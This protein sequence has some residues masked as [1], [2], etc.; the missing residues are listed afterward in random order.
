MKDHDKIKGQL[1]SELAEL[2][3]RIAELEA[4]ESESKQIEQALQESERQFRDLYENAPNA[5]LSVGVD[6]IVRRCNRR[7]AELLGYAMEDLVGRPVFELYADTPHGRGK[8]SQLFECFRAGEA[9]AG[10]EL[11]MQKADGTPLWI[12][13]TVNAVHDAHGQIVESRSMVVDITERKRAE[14]A[15]RESEERF[16]QMA[17]NTRDIFW[18]RDLK[19]RELIYVSPAYERLW[20]HS[21]QDA[22]SEPSS[23]MRNVHPEDRERVT[24]AFEKQ[25]RGEPT[26][27]EYRILW[28]DGSIRWIRDRAFPIQDQAG[29]PYRMVGV[30]EDFTDRKQVEK[31]LERR[32]TQ[33]ATLNR[34]GRYVESILDRQRLLQSAV[35]AVREELGYLQAA[36]LL[37]GVDDA[38]KEASELYVA[39]ATDNFW[40]IIPDNYRQPVGEGAIG[41]AAQTGETV[42]VRDASSDPRVY[43]IGE[44]L[45]PSSVSA[46]I[47]VG[48][49]VIE[50]LEVESDVPDAFD[51]NDLIVINTLA[52]QVAVAIENARLYQ[53]AKQE[54]S[55]RKQAEEERER[56]LVQIQ[57]QA[58]RVRQIIDT[59]PEGMLLLDADEQIVLANPVAEG[60]LSLLADVRVGGIVTRLG[61]RPL[62]ELLTSPPKGM[63]HEV[64]MDT[65][66]FQVIARPIEAGPTPGGWVMVIRDVTQQREIEQRVRQQERLA[67][68]GQL[69]AGIAHDFNNIMATI[70]L[71]A[72]MTAR[73]EGLPA[74]VRERMETIDQQ[75]Q[76]ATNLIQQIL[77]FSRRA[78]LER[79]PLDLALLLR[80]HVGLLKRTLPE[81]IE[82]ELDYGPGPSKAEEPDECA[83]PL[84]VNADPT[85]MQQMVTNLALNARDAMPEGGDLYIG[86][87]RIGVRPG[88]SPLLPEM[89]PG[90]WI[91]V[92]VSDT[93]TGIPPNVLPHIFEP[94][95]TTRAPLGSGLGLA[96][97]YGIV[98][99]HGGRID[100]DTEVGKGTTFTIYLP[101]HL[102]EQSATARSGGLSALATGQGEIILIVEDDTAVR[103]ALLDSL[104]GLNYTVL[105]A[106][107]GQEALTLL[108][109]YGDDIALLLSDVVMP[110]MGGMALLHALK[111]KGL[112]VPVVMLTGHLL[113]KELEDLRAQD[114]I[115]WLPKPPKLEQLAEVVA[116]ALGAD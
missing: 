71:Y 8:A 20:G 11:Q 99:Q 21:I 70:V 38:E 65:R 55:E 40:E 24:V 64:A 14:E 79:R 48:G 102:A 52:D 5:Y 3:R 59:V 66:S 44:W 78:V 101:V 73:M 75:A 111:E 41:M 95:F 114:I 92:T 84:I 106:A 116:R 37:L 47:K 33:L 39:A 56:L 16:R 69:A 2:C 88:E 82:I 49:R 22:Y 97:V 34:I 31:V 30:A 10:E 96:Q 17:E 98:G 58:Q 45:S 108:E 100:V 46:P 94:F 107:N 19:S 54:I 32:A 110:G 115:D 29:E 15:L 68:V 83:A 85:R 57:E 91:R 81:S 9:A 43:R 50:V 109:Q 53:A 87:E 63:W 90:E 112:R 23:W 77:D 13:L 27:N 72:Q 86:L 89:E 76:H 12:S 18:M 6:G 62:K 105:E 61:D 67:S 25:M 26:E 93:G 35:D 104:E 113:E 103:K 74:V 80:E 1:I 36:A 51:E 60:H 4:A 42:L 28:P 7:A